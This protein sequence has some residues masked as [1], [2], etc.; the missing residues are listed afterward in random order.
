MNRGFVIIG[1]LLMLLFIPVLFWAMSYEDVSSIEGGWQIITVKPG[2]QAF[3]AFMAIIG[4]LAFVTG[5]VMDDSKERARRAALYDWLFG[6]PSHSESDVYE[7]D[8]HSEV[9][10]YR[11]SRAKKIF[12]SSCGENIGNLAYCP[13]CGAKRE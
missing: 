2:A 4:F 1:A 10:I 3:F 9:P 8:P 13:F 5:M 11:G 12:C 6:R 7:L